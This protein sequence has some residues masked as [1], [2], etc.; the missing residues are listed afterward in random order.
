MQHSISVISYIPL[1]RL[2]FIVIYRY[3]YSASR[4]NC[5]ADGKRPINEPTGGAQNFV[6][7]ER[8]HQDTPIRA[9]ILDVSVVDRLYIRSR[10]FHTWMSSVSRD[11]GAN[12][13]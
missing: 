12:G 11:T 10:R 4:T 2:S 8:Q 1:G 5:N 6:A 13:R 7:E 3:S 9:I